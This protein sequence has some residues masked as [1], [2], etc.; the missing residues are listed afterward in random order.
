MVEEYELAGARGPA[1]FKQHCLSRR[2]MYT[3]TRWGY[4][5]GYGARQ[6]NPRVTRGTVPFRP[7]VQ[8]WVTSDFELN[9]RGV[10]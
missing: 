6:S 9:T 4:G 2:S 7:G 1:S 10:S 5:Y 8:S 3:R